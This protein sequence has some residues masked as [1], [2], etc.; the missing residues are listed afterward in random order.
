MSIPTTPRGAQRIAFSTM[1]SFWC[2][3]NVRSI[4][5]IR[6]ART[7]GYSR[8]A[9][10]SPR[11]AA[12]MMWSRSRSPPRF[13]FIGVKR[14][15]SVVIPCDRYAP[16]IASWAEEREPRGD[17]DVERDPDADHA[18]AVGQSECGEQDEERARGEHRPHQE[19]GVAGADEDP[20]EGEDGAAERLHQGEERPQERSL[21]ED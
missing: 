19:A 6:P 1:T 18:P 12:R 2:G 5:R 10:S 15:S 9:T 3:E 8:L 21:V 13:R 11:I 16:P 17:E 4:I 20:V 14:S 7:W